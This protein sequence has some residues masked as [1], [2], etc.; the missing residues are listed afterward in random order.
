M[1]ALKGCGK[2]KLARAAASTC[3]SVFLAASAASIF[4]PYVGDSEKAVAEL[5]SRARMASPSVLFIDEIGERRRHLSFWSTFS[6][7]CIGEL[8]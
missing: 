1:L 4:S 5:F 3:G 2:T 7:R 8:S 6:L